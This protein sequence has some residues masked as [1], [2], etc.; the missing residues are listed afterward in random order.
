MAFCD[1]LFSFIIMFS[2]F[3]QVVACNSTSFIFIAEWYSIVWIHYILSI[4]SSIYGHLCC[5][6]FLAITNNGAMNIAYRFLKNNL[7]IFG[8]VGS[9]LL[10]V[11]FSLGFSLVAES[12]G[13]SSLQCVGFSLQWLLLLRS[14]GS[15]RAGFS[16]CGSRALER[17]LSSCGTRA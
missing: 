7:F 5:I 4:H 13:Y 17:R 1:C 8:C 2:R 3:I 14:T 9:S 15:R 11:G 10:C 6:H 12:R 16:S